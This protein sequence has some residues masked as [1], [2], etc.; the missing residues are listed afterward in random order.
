MRRNTTGARVTEAAAGLERITHL[1]EQLAFAPVNSGQ[2]RTLRAAIRIEADAYRK[3]L[4][5]EQATATH[6]TKPQ[7]AVGLEPLSR[8]FGSR[9][10]TLV[11]RRRSHHTIR[12]ALR[13]HAS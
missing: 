7:P 10:P 13:T 8:T 4:D 2:H 6:D 12:A 11:P 3:S 5:V 9:T 1:E